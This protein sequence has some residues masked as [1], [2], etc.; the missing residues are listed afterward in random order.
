M[1]DRNVEERSRMHISSFEAIN[2]KSFLS[3]GQMKLEP[4]FN[5][6]VGQNNV[7]KT[8]LAETLSLNLVANPHRSQKTIPVAGG[9]PADPHSSARVTLGISAEELREIV[10]RKRLPDPLYVLVKSHNETSSAAFQVRHLLDSGPSISAFYTTTDANTPA[11][12][13]TRA[14]LVGYETASTN[15]G[16]I[17]FLSDYDTGTLRYDP[18]VFGSGGSNSQ[19]EI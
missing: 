6:V 11:L 18:S 2:Y 19:Y 13:L 17:Q 7:G 1:L 16:F 5:V 8:A 9:V 4:G 15:S 12:A 14:S 3:S 10:K